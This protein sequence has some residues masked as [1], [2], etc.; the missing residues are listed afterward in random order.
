MPVY[1]SITIDSGHTG[2]LG[3]LWCM[4]CKHTLASKATDRTG[5]TH[6]SV[7]G[8]RKLH[9]GFLVQL[10]QPERWLLVNYNATSNA[11]LTFTLYEET[12]RILCQLPTSIFHTASIVNRQTM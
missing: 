10:E 3:S 12:R 4:G 11:S 5:F 6:H 1:A 2:P 7:T 9:A 8:T